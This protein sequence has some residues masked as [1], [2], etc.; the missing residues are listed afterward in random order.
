MVVIGK[1]PV[2][3]YEALISPYRGQTFGPEARKVYTFY[4][5]EVPSS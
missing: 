3:V 5:E 1:V 2:A 4:D